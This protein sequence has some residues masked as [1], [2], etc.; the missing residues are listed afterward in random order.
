MARGIVVIPK[1]TKPARI[2]ENLHTVTLDASDV[3]TLMEIHKKKGTK[4]M[5]YPPFGHN[6]GFPDKEEFHASQKK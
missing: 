6:F 5:V 2:E 1:T 4:R 3:D